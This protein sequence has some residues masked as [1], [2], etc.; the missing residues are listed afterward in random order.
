MFTDLTPTSKDTVWQTGL[1]RKIQQSVV[2]RRHISLTETSTGLEWKAGRRFSKPIAPKTGRSSN[3]Y[4][5]QSRLQTYIDQM[6]WRRTFHTN[7]RRNTPK[8]SN[9]YQLICTHF[10]APNFIKHTLKDLKAYID[11]STVVVGDINT[12]YHQQKLQQK[13]GKQLEAE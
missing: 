3:T 6:R 13:I 2:Y 8:G 9:N 10:S 11:S 4:P 5:R 7:K 12:P 1:K